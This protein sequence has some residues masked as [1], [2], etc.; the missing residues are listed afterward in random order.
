MKWSCFSRVAWL[1]LLLVISPFWHNNVAHAQRAGTSEVPVASADSQPRLVVRLGHTFQVKSIAFSPDGNFLLTREVGLGDT[2]CLWETTTGREIRRFGGHSAGI[3]SVAFSP[4]GRSVLTASIDG[5]ATLWDM[6]TGKEV[7][8]FEKSA[9]DGIRSV[10]FSP[11]G[12]FVLIADRSSA[13]LLDVTTGKKV[14]AFEGHTGY[15]TDVVFSS[16]GRFVL[17]GSVDSTARLWDAATGREIG[18]S[19][20]VGKTA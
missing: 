10:A 13:L 12:H 19:Q 7:R 11:D 8:R 3:A 1:T 2:A 9:S 18:V 15:L 14:R 4:D 5:T 17:T 16:D 6:L 20:P